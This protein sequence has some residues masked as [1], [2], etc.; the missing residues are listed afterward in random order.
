M[1]I[2][3][4]EREALEHARLL[5]A[6]AARSA[7]SDPPPESHVQEALER[8]FAYLVSLEAQDQR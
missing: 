3:E 7:G 6:L 4:L 5:H 1:E 8:G 2:G